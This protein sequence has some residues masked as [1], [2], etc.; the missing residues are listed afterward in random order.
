[1]PPPR[2]REQLEGLDAF[3]ACLRGARRS[4]CVEHVLEDGGILGAFGAFGA[5]AELGGDVDG[6]EVPMTLLR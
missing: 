2:C 1:V 5:S 3:A 6:A 4:G